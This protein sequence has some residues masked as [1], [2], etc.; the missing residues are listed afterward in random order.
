MTMSKSRLAYRQEYDLMDTAMK[1]DKGSRTHIG[2]RE[3]AKTYQLR[4]NM[5]RQLD[6][7]LNREAFPEGHLLHGASEYDELVFRIKID[8]DDEWWVY[9]EKALAPTVVEAIE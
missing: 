8:T 9:L 5:A 6:R 4:L 2:S 1:T 3:A 7:K